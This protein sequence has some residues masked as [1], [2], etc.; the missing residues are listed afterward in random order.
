MQ[1]QKDMQ[2]QIN[3]RNDLFVAIGARFPHPNHLKSDHRHI[4]MEDCFLKHL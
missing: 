2:D 4:S 1:D 3:T